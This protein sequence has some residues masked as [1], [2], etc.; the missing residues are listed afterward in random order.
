[1]VLGFLVSGPLRRYLDGGKVRV[2][3]LIVAAGSAVALIVQNLVTQ[4]M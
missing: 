1:M 2:A 3:V 4:V